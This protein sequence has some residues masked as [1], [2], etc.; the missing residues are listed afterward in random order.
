MVEELVIFAVLWLNAFPP[1]TGVSQTLSPCV[2]FTGTSL[3]LKKHCRI[4]FGAYAQTY[5][6]G[7]NNM[8]RR[9]L[10]AIALGPVSN[11]Q[12]SYKFMSLHTSRLIVRCDFDELPVTEEVIAQ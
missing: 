4:L 3:N 6:E 7:S 9:T 10:G 12:G 11:A 5:E 8:D 2:I 1:R